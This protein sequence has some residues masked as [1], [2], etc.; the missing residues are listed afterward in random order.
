MAIFQPSNIIPSSFAGIGLG[1]LD[2]NDN[3][4]ISWQVNGNSPMTAFQIQIYNNTQVA[5][6]NPIYNTGVL[7]VGIPTGGF[8]GVDNKGNPKQFLYTPNETWANWG[9]TNGN[10]YKMIITQYWG[11]NNSQSITEWS[12]SVF[13]TRTTPTLILQ[14]NN[15]NFDGSAP[16]ENAIATFTAVY[17]QA[18]FDSINYVRWQV[19]DSQNQ[20][21]EDTG[22]INTSELSYTYNKF[23]TNNTYSINCIVETQNGI[24][25]S[26]GWVDFAVSYP[27]ANSTGGVNVRFTNDNAVLVSWQQA[28]DIPGTLSSGELNINDGTLTLDNTQSV[29]WDSVNN[30][31]MNFEPYW[32]LSSKQNIWNKK[33]YSI[34]TDNFAIS[35]N[36]KILV[37]CRSSE[38]AKIYDIVNNELVYRSELTIPNEPKNSGYGAFSSDGNY[39][40]LLGRGCRVYKVDGNGNF[41]YLTE[42]LYENERVNAFTVVF[43][44]TTNCFVVCT[45]SRTGYSQKSYPCLVYKIES[46]NSVTTYDKLPQPNT[47]FVYPERFAVTVAFSNDGQSLFLSCGNGL[48][49][50]QY[51]VDY[52]QTALNWSYQLIYEDTSVNI[53]QALLMTSKN[54][55]IGISGKTLSNSEMSI[56]LYKINNGVWQLSSTTK[57]FDF[58][59]DDNESYLAISNDGNSLLCGRDYYLEIFKVNSDSLTSIRTVNNFSNRTHSIHY[60]GFIDNNTILFSETDDTTVSGIKPNTL[61]LISSNLTGFYI[62]QTAIFYNL[63]AYSWYTLIQNDEIKVNSLGVCQISDIIV[64]SVVI[65]TINSIEI[66]GPQV[67]DYIY[68]TSNSNA[69]ETFNNTNLVWDSNTLFW[70]NFNNDGLQ[71]GTLSTSGDITNYLYRFE[72]GEFQFVAEFPTVITEF[73]DYT[74][75]SGKAYSYELFYVNINSG[76]S[77]PAQ[78]NQICK[79]FSKYSLLEAVQDVQNPNLYYVVKEWGFGNNIS[80]GVVSNNNTPNWLT[81]FTPYRLKQP[82]STLGKS[83]TLQALLSNYNTNKN[84]YADTVQ[85]MESLYQASQSNNTF[86]L[87]DMKGNLY[88]VG[89][90]APIS[91][92]IETKTKVQQVTISLSW[93]EVG[94]VENVSIISIVTDNQQLSQN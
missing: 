24:Q 75:R 50:Y 47:S 86:F 54:V 44:P 19:R 55:L 64:Q 85:M 94:N 26:T 11:D 31:S 62:N 22:L 91:Q 83:G 53:H 69:E 57:Y 67:I 63:P 70:A 33:D 93:E 49:L 36:K 42:V 16:I 38:W 1:V 82:S 37:C 10:E 60:I 18:Q 4:N 15:S 48:H 78:S 2:V 73:K 9:L 51:T 29:S 81:N 35:P 5:N 68:I 79:R 3:I 89:I 59:A 52:N 88:M 27:L 14:Y 87:K 20:I 72:N 6:A 40:V 58:S 8:Y 17:E 41:T 80:V 39:F 32:F 74:V 77:S 12:G 25:V 71:A 43:S 92:T 90:S 30:E 34:A 45:K 23:F 13:I 28:L 61:S 84:F 66:I 65:G 21:L 56:Y 46:N 76:F 7:T